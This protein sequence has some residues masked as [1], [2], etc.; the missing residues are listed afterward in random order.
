[1]TIAAIINIHKNGTEKSYPEL[2]ISYICAGIPIWRD[3]C[4]GL[5]WVHGTTPIKFILPN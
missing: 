5:G 4:L 1:M 3:R 2:G